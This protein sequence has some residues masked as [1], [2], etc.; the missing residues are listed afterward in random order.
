MKSWYSL[1]VRHGWLLHE[2][3]ENVF[4]CQHETERNKQFL[5]QSLE[6]ANLSYDYDGKTLM[7][8]S[9]PM[10]EEAWISILDFENRGRGGD[11]WF[12]PGEEEPKIKELDT[13]ISGIVRQF[14]RL[15]FYTN[16][17]CHGHGRHAAYVSVIKKE[18]NIYQ[19]KQL[20]L[21]LG[22][23]VTRSRD[24]G[25]SYVLYFPL[26][27]KELLDIAEKMSVMKV[28]WLEQGMDYVEEQLF[29]TELEEMLSIPGASGKE[30]QI[31]E[32]V[33]EKL[34]PYVD[35]I[36]VDRYGNLLAEKTYRTGR[37]P[38]IVLNAHLDTVSE[39]VKGRSI[40]KE[41]GIWSSSEG[42]LGAD[43]RAGV[44]VL[45][46]VAKMVSHFPA[47]SGK[48]KFIFTVEEEAGLIGAS[49]VD[50]YFLWG[51]DAAIVVDR[52]GTSDIVTSCL[53]MIPFCEDEYGKFIEQVAKE[54][55][56]TGWKCT[57]GGSSD[58]TIWASHGI[59]SVNLSVGYH[60]EHTKA[61]CLDIR[62]CYK[63]TQLIRTFLEKER[64]LVRTLRMMRRKRMDYAN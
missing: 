57:Q 48:I 28:E 50:E 2:K 64:E 44:A 7:M 11:L 15:G 49:K 21:A 41:N 31:R 26:K 43:D 3:E 13:Y 22:V 16:G 36:T 9:Q 14:N 46:H 23:K 40:R 12:R 59:Q 29:Y 53:G 4:D 38:T 33:K 25:R 19:L 54:A 56:L 58:T 63:T 6:Q 47:F 17:S 10:K 5:L 34:T 32:K 62:A 1:F 27:S 51:T 55:G 37:G 39:I 30:Q 24:N 52:R 18:N 8:Y 45:L 35:F 61:E 20:L 42:I 60:H